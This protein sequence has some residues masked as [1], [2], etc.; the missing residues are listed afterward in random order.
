MGGYQFSELIA[1]FQTD[2]SAPVF[3]GGNAALGDFYDGTIR[4]LSLRGGYR[5]GKNLTWTANWISNFINLPE[6]EFNTNLIGLRFNWSF[7]PKSF[8]QTFSQYDSVTHEI[9]H[10]IRLGLLSTSSTGFFVVFN[11]ATTTVGFLDPHDVE[12]R[13]ISRGLF[14]K[15]THL[16]DY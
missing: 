8:L 3:F 11:T 13:T 4:S 12:R 1:N 15:F 6:G 7:T 2:P 14:I 9:G 10:N 16:L 5:R